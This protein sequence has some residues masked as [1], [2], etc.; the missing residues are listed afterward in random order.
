M[1]H[2]FDVS[3][4]KKLSSEERR[5]LLTP[6]ETLI[7][8]GYKKGD[9]LADIGCGTG[10]FTFP[11]AKIS[12]DTKVYAVDIS[13]QMLD[14]VKNE[15]EREQF[16]NIVPVKS[17]EYDFRLENESADFILLCTVLHEVD[18]KPR[19]LA[20]AARICRSGGTVAVI[21]F[22]E[23]PI[24]GPPLNHRISKSLT[25]E[26][27]NANGLSVVQSFDVSEAFYA[28]AAKKQSK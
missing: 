14:E 11:A 3:A 27:L 12:P 28:V 18:N 5:K 19:L 7:K 4:R 24:Y 25:E 8:L 9:I 6:N 26:L 16:N 15:A 20:E 13:Q 1:A 21:E 10:L 22:N 17:E 2:K 23:N